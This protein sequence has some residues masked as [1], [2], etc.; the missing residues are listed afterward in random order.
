MAAVA[1]VLGGCPKVPPARDPNVGRVCVNVREINSI[2]ALEDD[3]HAFVVAGSNRYYLLNLDKGCMDIR[4]ARG[5]AIGDGRS[6]VCGDGFSFLSFQHP[7]L[8]PMRCRIEGMVEVESKAA[9]RE[10]IEAEA[11]E[12]P[13]RP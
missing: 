9:A 4:F 13:E 11:S 2:G 6:R 12:E 10:L 5:I 7:D 3:Q 8:G 1:V